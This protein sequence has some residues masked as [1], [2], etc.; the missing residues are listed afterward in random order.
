MP[1]MCVQFWKDAVLWITGLVSGWTGVAIKPPA[2]KRST[3]S[4]QVSTSINDQGI[5][6]SELA[7]EVIVLDFAVAGEI[8]KAFEVATEQKVD[9]VLPLSDPMA[10]GNAARI[11]ALSLTHRIP[12]VSPFRRLP[13]LEDC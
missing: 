1:P 12:C 10:L 5:Y 13:M 6:R 3:S 8:E 9:A 11:G 4:A 2:N 7:L